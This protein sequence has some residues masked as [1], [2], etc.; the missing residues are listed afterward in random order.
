MATKHLQQ[1]LTSDRDKE[2]DEQTL[3]IEDLK[4]SVG[5]G[6]RLDSEDIASTYHSDEKFLAALEARRNETSTA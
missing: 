3:K 4:A 2:E 5:K 6:P 1:G